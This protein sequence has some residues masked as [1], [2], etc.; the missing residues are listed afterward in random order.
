[1]IDNF[2]RFFSIP[3]SYK[4]I[5]LPGSDDDLPKA[6]YGSCGNTNQTDQYI[7]IEWRENDDV[8]SLNLIFRLNKTKTPEFSLYKAIFNLSSKVVP[9]SGQNRTVLYHI[10]NILEN[11]KDRS[12]HCTKVRTFNLTKAPAEK[13]ELAGTFSLSSVL[14]E[15]YH[16]ANNKNYSNSIDCEGMNTP[17]K[18]KIFNH[19]LYKLCIITN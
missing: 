13:S 14:V 8:N 4:I 5:N 9:N 18:M 3:D 6:A 15:A 2:F 12:Y 11:P 19:T 7:V 10:G 16:S 1:M 17:G